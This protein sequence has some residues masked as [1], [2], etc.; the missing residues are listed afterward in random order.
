LD[1]AAKTLD[2]SNAAAVARAGSWATYVD[3]TSRF[4]GHG[5]CAGSAWINPVT[6]KASVDLKT[7]KVVTVVDPGSVHPTVDGQAHGYADAYAA[8]GI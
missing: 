6:V 8:A 3:V 1:T 2:A 5:L 7:S 4:A